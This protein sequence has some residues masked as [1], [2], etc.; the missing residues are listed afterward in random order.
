[1]SKGVGWWTQGM[2]FLPEQGVNFFMDFF[3]I[4]LFIMDF[5]ILD[6]FIIISKPS[7][8]EEGIRFL[9]ILWWCILSSN[10]KLIWP[11]LSQFVPRNLVKMVDRVF[12]Q[13]LNFFRVLQLHLSL[14]V[15]DPLICKY[16][17]SQNR[18]KDFFNQ[19]WMCKNSKA[20]ISFLVKMTLWR[21]FPGSQKWLRSKLSLCMYSLLR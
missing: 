4:C 6:F 9:C 17:G 11:P 5:P 19:K 8:P 10:I 14:P 15:T 18:N 16:L 2:K 21:N 3:I 12:T 20:I 1:M 13:N 7:L